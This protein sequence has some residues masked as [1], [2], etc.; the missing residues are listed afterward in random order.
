MKRY[1][2]S[3]ADRYCY[4]QSN[5]THIIEADSLESARILAMDW[6]KAHGGTEG[7]SWSV[8]QL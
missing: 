6:L 5:G 3:Y 4:V 8:T 1:K 7:L 2:L